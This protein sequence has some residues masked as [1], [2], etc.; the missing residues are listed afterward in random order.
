M[1]DFR[2][3]KLIKLDGV[4]GAVLLVR[5]EAHRRGLI[6]PS[7]RKWIEPW[8]CFIWFTAQVINIFYF[9]PLAFEHQLETEGLAKMAK[10][11]GYESWGMPQL[12]CVHY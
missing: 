6:F 10:A 12:L 3:Q 9:S 4:G 8:C 1:H 7:F 2:D 11:M 5:A